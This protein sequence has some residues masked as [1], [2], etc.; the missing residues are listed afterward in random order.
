M[1]TRTA[2][3]PLVVFA[4]AAAGS[5]V[6][7]YDFFAY[8]TAAALVFPT[9][10]FPS[11]GT[12][13]AR[14]ASFATLGAAFVARPAGAMVF[15]HFGD[16][17][18]RKRILVVTL[19]LMGAATVGV[20][21]VPGADRIGFAAPALVLGLRLVQGFA[22][23]GEMGGAV[24][25]SAESAPPG[26]SGLMG[27]AGAVGASLG[28]LLSSLSFLAV[29]LLGAAQSSA[30]LAWGWR[31]PFL[32]SGLLILIGLVVRRRVSESPAFVAARES[33]ALVRAPLLQ[34]VRERPGQL[35]L[36]TGAVCALYVVSFFRDSFLVSVA[37]NELG[38]SFSE[39]LKINVGGGVV[40]F[41]VVVATGY[42]SDKFPRKAV[43]IVGLVL[44]SIW[45]VAVM[46][47]LLSGAPEAFAL[48]TLISV[49]ALG[50]ANGAIA[51]FLVEDFPVQLR[52]TGFAVAFNVA[53]VLGGALPPILA[54][55]LYSSRGASAVGLM[56]LVFALF[57]LACAV[58]TTRFAQAHSREA[59][60]AEL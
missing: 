18:G 19:L 34:L 12:E 46:P 55:S 60:A 17:L 11:L 57:S 16:R 6:E 39:I 29:S 49:L 23:G 52:Y 31:V 10:F 24:V 21:L 47:V 32:L 50:V 9:V 33:G 54:T 42:L 7:F 48:A 37:R 53:G 20:G 38:L 3:S 26:R 45:S 4:A 56:L 59:A 13:A 22:V 15:G 1:M 28:F 41:L 44:I 40:W 30:F 8:G 36:V 51:P 43:Y 14:L 27:S 5:A 35:A 58:A 25:L 2:P